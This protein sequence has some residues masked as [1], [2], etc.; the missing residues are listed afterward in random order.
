MIP[1]E[2]RPVTSSS[3]RAA[4]V[5]TLLRHSMRSSREN[6]IDG[7]RTCGLDV[8][9]AAR[10]PGPLGRDAYRIVQEALTN[11]HKHAKGAATTVSVTGGPAEGL[12]VSVRNRL[13]A[14]AARS[15][16]LPGG[17]AGL[18]GLT[19]RVDLSGGSFRHGR[20][21]VGVFE[22][23]AELLWPGERTP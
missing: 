6:G 9:D 16:V 22:V 7:G 2:S 19:E 3:Q 4:R 11:V 5:S 14:A 13:P 1:T 20:T 10:A 21:D 23:A 17:G 18:L 15:W 12:S 8:P